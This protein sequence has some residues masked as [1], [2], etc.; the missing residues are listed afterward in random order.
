VRHLASL[1]FV[2]TL[3]ACAPTA[4]PEPGRNSRDFERGGLFGHLLDGKYDAAGHPLGAHVFEAERDCRHETGALEVE[5]W[6]AL[7]GEHGAGLLCRVET[8]RLGGSLIL[9]ARALAQQPACDPEAAAFTLRARDASGELVGERVVK[10]SELADGLVYRNFTVSLRTSGASS[11]TLE[12]E[13]PGAAAVRLDYLEVFPAEPRLLVGPRSGVPPSGARFQIDLAQPAAGM[14]LAL[15]CDG[16]DLTERLHQLAAESGAES[17]NELDMTVSAPADQL[18]EACGGVGRVRARALKGDWARETSRVTYLKEEPPCSFE[19]GKRRVLISGFEP[20]PADYSGDNASE[21]AVLGFD[22][23]ALP[24]VSVMRVILPVEWDTAAELLG[25][26]VD[27][28][29]PEVVVSFGQ[30]RQRVEIE[31]LAHNEK[32]GSELAAGIPDNRGAMPEEREIVAGA[33]GSLPSRLPVVGVLAGLKE[34]GVDAGTSEDAGRFIC[35]NLFYAMMYKLADGP[36]AGGFVH[37]PSIY[38]VGPED[39]RQLQATVRAVIERT[40]KQVTPPPAP[41]PAGK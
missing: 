1:L 36:I 2:V 4:E 22:A 30:G 11:L 31:V 16:T 6:G 15:D 5:G 40:L 12:V 35:N 20:F 14:K 26:V 38:K 27:R 34:A 10:G 37:L 33:P 13:W 32:S 17:T 21:R 24:G 9:N 3:I 39:Q 23:S 25:R 19:P 7:P 41:A 28:C 8:P 29:Q 18:L